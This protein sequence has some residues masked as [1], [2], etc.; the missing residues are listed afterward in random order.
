MSRI[1][2][3]T[4]CRCSAPAGAYV[5]TIG[6][7]GADG[8]DFDHLSGPNGLAVDTVD[9]LYI[10]DAWNNRVQVFDRMARI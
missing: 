8:D 5:R 1:G 7:T 9:R 2:T 10:V 6:V 4:G 3:T